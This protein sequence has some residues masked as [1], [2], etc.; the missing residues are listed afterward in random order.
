MFELIFIPRLILAIMLG[1]I[2][3][4]QRER[5]GRDAGPRTYALVC[6]GSALFT[7]LSIYGFSNGDTARIAAQI[8]T[9][10]G[11]LGAGIIMKKEDHI[12]GLTTAAGLW[13]S[14]AIGMGVGAGYF[15]LSTIATILVLL[16]LALDDNKIVK[17]KE[18]KK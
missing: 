12:K 7:I 9:G 18:L 8:V 2:L 10:I 6:V 15:L 5:L 16:V 4:W 3:G 13:V 17:R 14:A 1:G 11:F